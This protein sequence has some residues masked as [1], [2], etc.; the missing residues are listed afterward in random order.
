MSYLFK[1]SVSDEMV[2]ASWKSGAANRVEK[3]ANQGMMRGTV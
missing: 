1:I 2:G 3:R